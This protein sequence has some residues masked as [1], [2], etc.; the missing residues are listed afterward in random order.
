LHSLDSEGRLIAVSGA[1]LHKF[2]YSRDEVLGK[3]YLDFLTPNSRAFALREAVS[4]FYRTGRQENVSYQMVCKDGRVLDVLVS[5]ALDPGDAG[6]ESSALAVITDVTDLRVAERKAAEKQ[7]VYEGI[8]ES[9]AELVSLAK[10][11]GEIT[12]VNQ[13]YARHYNREP[14]E[15]IGTNLLDYVP[16][17]ARDAVEEL[18][19]EVCC[20]AATIE[21]ENL[22]AATNGETRWIAWTNRAI[23]APDGSV[24]AIQ[25]VGRDIERRVLAERR[26]KESEARYRLLADNVSDMVLQIDRDLVRRY[27]SPSSREL[28]G[29][30]PTELIGLSPIELCHPDD[31]HI[32]AQATRALLA[33]EAERKTVVQRSRHRDGRWVWL[34]SEIKA[35]RDPETGEICGIVGVARNVSNRI[36]AERCV[37]ESEARY[38]LLADNVS[39]MVIRYD[40][41]LVR[42][43][44]S[45]ASLDIL[46]YEPSELVNGKPL[47]VCHPD[48]VDAAAAAFRALSAG[49]AERQTLINRRRHRDGRWI[50]AE[51]ELK[52][53]RDPVSGEFCGV[54]G[55][56][57]DISK[58]KAIEDELAE[59]HRRMEILATRDGLSGLANRRS[60]DETLDKEYRRAARE[61]SDLAL[62]M[63]DVDRFKGFND[64]YGHP[65]GDVCLKQVALAISGV[66]RRPADFAA[67]YGGEEFAVLLPNTHESGAVEIAERIRLAVRELGIPNARG[68][69]GL[70]TISAGAAVTP[71]GER[72][73]WPHLLLLDADRALYKAKKAGRDHV[74]NASWLLAGEPKAKSRRQNRSTPRRR[75]TVNSS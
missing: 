39:D 61:G 64:L 59:A 9:Q 29:Y 57:R 65:A 8:V 41:D 40:R 71:K 15:L 50:W 5:A 66:I 3:K 58:R 1:W 48:D 63:I 6:R 10:P 7:V 51:V 42:R 25:S 28:L 67:R 22:V 44:V 68:I 24:T 33:G 46:G 43:Y 12:F 54:I 69:D 37:K 38:R 36:E 47:D 31:Q 73:D 11:N 62:I 27:I 20:S 18:L 52:A 45:P 30:D 35:L 26:L 49:E 53:L 55:A 70:V 72:G 23:F 16:A 60:F 13:A 14:H 32:M 74:F 56:V 19:R 4:E 75:S 21:S 34:E 17:D 2:G